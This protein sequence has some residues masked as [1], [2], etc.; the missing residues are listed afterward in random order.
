MSG[1]SLAAGNFSVAVA[2]DSGPDYVLQ[3]TTNLSS[4]ASWASIVTNASAS[5]PFQFVAAAATNAPQKFY[6]VVLQP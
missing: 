5:P 1:P 2:G 4:A 6:R 3:A